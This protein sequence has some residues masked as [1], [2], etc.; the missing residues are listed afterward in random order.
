MPRREL[1]IIYR[2][3]VEDSS[4]SP[5][6]RSRKDDGRCLTS[7]P[8]RGPV[9]SNVSTLDKELKSLKDL[10]YSQT[11]RLSQRAELSTS[12]PNCTNIVKEIPKLKSFVFI[13]SSSGSRHL[14]GL[15]GSAM[16][17]ENVEEDNE[18]RQLEENLH[19]QQE[20]LDAMTKRIALTC[21]R[22]QNA[23][24]AVVM[25]PQ[26]SVLSATTDQE[27][28]DLA[29]IMHMLARRQ[30]EEDTEGCLSGPVGEDEVSP[31]CIEDE[32]ASCSVCSPTSPKTDKSFAHQLGNS[33]GNR[34]G[35]NSTKV[36]MDL[37]PNMRAI[38]VL[39]PSEVGSVRKGDILSGDNVLKVDAHEA[40]RTQ[41]GALGIIS[42]APFFRM[43]PKLSVAGVAQP[44]A[45]SLRT[46]IN[47]LRRVF[48]GSV[49][50]VNLREEPLVYINNEAYVVRQRSDPTVP[51][52]IPHITG[53]SIS[54]IDEKLKR[55][56]LKEASENSGNVSVQME[57]KDGHMED[58]WESAERDQVFTLKDLFGMLKE[59]V[60]YHR[61][62]ITYN[63]GPQP[64]DFDFVFN[65]CMDDPRTM[66]IFNCQTGRGK[67]SAMMTIASIVRFYQV[68]AHDALLDTALVRHG[69]R[70]FS[71]RTI[72][73]IVSL[74]PHGKHHE[75][76]LFLVLDITDKVYSLT[77]HINNAFN[78]GTASPEEAI[79][80]L[81]QYAYFLVF[82]YYC[83]QRIW[84]LA[85]KERFS[86]WLKKNN[87]ISILIGKIDSME[88]E[89]AEE[90]IAV[91][92][93]GD[94]EEEMA[95][96]VRSRKGTV[97]SAN[98]ILC[99]LFSA[100]KET[101][102]TIESLRQL[103]P[104]V[105]IFTS[106]A[107]SDADRY[108]LISDVRKCF[109]GGK[110]MWMNLRA[111]PIVFINNVGYL[112]M[113]YDVTDYKTC[114]TGITMHTSLQAI[115]QIEERLR[116]DV[117][118]E[119]QEHKGMILL[120][121]FE[122]SGKRV[123][124][125]VKVCTVKTPK[126]VMADFA[127]ACGINY[128]RIP[129]PY[130]GSMLPSDIDPLLE[131]L[132]KR[133]EDHSIF[134]INDSQTSVRTTVAL[135]VL[136]M[137][138]ASRRCNLRMLSSPTKIVHFLRAAGSNVVVPRVNVVGYQDTGSDSSPRTNNEL[139]VAST[140]CQ[141]LTAGSLMR[142]VSAIIELGGR[143]E[144]WNIIDKLNSIKESI[145]RSA[146][147]KAKGLREAIGIVRSY[148]LVL[149][150]TIYVDLQGGYNNKEP[151]NI[152]LG[153]RGEVANIMSNLDSR[154]EPSIKYITHISVAG[155]YVAARHGD[156]LT[157]NYVLKADH[158]PGCQ[159][160]GIRPELCGAP[161]FRKVQSV[162][163]YGVA[164]PTII[165]IHNI[166]SLLG[167]SQAPLQ[168]YAGAQND[169]EI[170]MGF[171]AP[172]L[173]DPRFRS[174][175][176]NKPLRGHVVWV[177]LREEPILYV[178]D[179]PFV[180]RNIETPYV[181]VELTGI[182]AHEVE[183]VEKQLLADVLKEAEENKGL[184]LVHDEKTPG[185]LQ[186]S[187][188]AA[189]AETVKTL[190]D[191]YC[192]LVMQGHRVTLLRLPVTDEQSPSESSFD[193]LVDSLLP[194]ITSRMDRRET[195]S[196]VFNCQMGR[197]RT[198][199]GMVVCCLLIGLV[200][201][202]YYKELDSIYNPLYA[203][204]ESQ[205]SRGDYGCVLQLKRALS[206]G[207][208]AK[209]RVDVVIE[210]CSRMQNL[211]TAIEVFALQA[212][213]PDVAEEQRGRAH[214]QGVHYLRR[215]FNLIAFAAYLEE[216]YDPMKKNMK[217]TFSYWLTQRRDITVLCESAVLK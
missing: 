176:V 134:I 148:L 195:L 183:H 177:N 85:T 28:I 104:G 105:P 14:P 128:Y 132:C 51:M 121:T 123:A 10:W 38:V 69:V 114:G 115:E 113:D 11:E 61:C 49:V 89:F 3:Y 201:P 59:S 141:M 163:V 67:T 124:V 81:K 180:L 211:R 103:A 209:H 137:C 66:I 42:G 129:M 158:F 111:E 107:L 217:C 150:S 75:R 63:V 160:K 23:E 202:E 208:E 101:E 116:R 27:V 164:I 144:Q 43:V 143:G 110:I 196:F 102:G 207:R 186:G 97:L 130:G 30:E 199:T 140:I 83:E 9:S 151:F 36:F 96:I 7:F 64:Q 215:Y 44:R 204:D 6:D 170:H 33:N 93:T 206:G 173:F 92:I 138:C 205:L 56:V 139:Q 57:V 91:P 41:K 58:Q 8:T 47:E 86:V 194:H 21:R 133:S 191:V 31:S 135:N 48:D 162:N 182:A 90:R 185:E 200:M 40:L 45:S 181:N 46:I 25:P 149:L 80:Y 112:L 32:R 29:D 156:V 18:V 117:S 87:E 73:K 166:L 187:W 168:T 13:P 62:P 152:W 53:E 108:T 147:E 37:V 153:Q 39:S 192:D 54:L 122:E 179:K 35:V 165:G 26:P 68:F 190:R 52:I 174:E 74:I 145:A 131:H 1:P 127:A 157:S 118:L 79:M 106:G 125:R 70:C 210:A 100:E 50:W 184:F 161:N 109:P 212:Q 95:K 20:R 203:P 2:T 84:N 189:T 82:S 213:S 34:T 169:E 4:N 5:G 172:R 19:R 72:K 60:T 22:R 198:T 126:A 71:F 76:R 216:Q 171:A 188:E 159:K 12:L 55:E 119:A 24:N 193:A 214:H 146:V 88:E 175:L 178:G 120:H 77:D 15:D 98:R 197:G 78:A 155:P 16:R 17:K 136:T 154:G 99:R 65:L 94:D 142:V 167:A